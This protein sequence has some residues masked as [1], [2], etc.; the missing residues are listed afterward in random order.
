L[1]LPRDILISWAGFASVD[2]HCTEGGFFDVRICWT[3]DSSSIVYDASR[4]ATLIGGL[5]D[6]NVGKSFPTPGIIVPGDRYITWGIDNHCENTDNDDSDDYY[7]ERTIRGH[8]APKQYIRQ[9]N[10]IF[11]YHELL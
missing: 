10:A 4:C 11:G 3:A 8:K 5:T 7:D 6:T 2:K 1:Y 9:W